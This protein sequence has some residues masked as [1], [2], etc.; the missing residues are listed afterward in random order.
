MLKK[1]VG[2]I[3]DD[4][5]TFVRQT[6]LNAFQMEFLQN[7]LTPLSELIIQ[8]NVQHNDYFTERFL[9][10]LKQLYFTDQISDA[11]KKWFGWEND[12]SIY[13]QLFDI[14]IHTFLLIVETIFQ[15][16]R[17]DCVFLAVFY[18]MVI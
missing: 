14:E 15:V 12:E 18:T 1:E 3:L 16:Y 9:E 11:L 17:Y 4:I 8:L 10:I 2:P 13:A 6:H 7:I 5:I